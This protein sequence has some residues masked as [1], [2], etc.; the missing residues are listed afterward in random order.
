MCSCKVENYSEISEKLKNILNLDKNPVAVKLFLS[1]QKAEEVLP[2]AE[3]KKRHCERVFDAAEGV[4]CY[5]TLDEQLCQGGAAAL[6]LRDFPDALKTGE[7]YYSLGRFASEGSAKH[8]LE[9]IPKVDTIME[10]V[11]YAPL[12]EAKFEADVIVI[13]ATPEQAMKISQAY[14]YV[15]GKRFKSSFA[16]IQSICSDVVA[17]PF[18][19]KEPNLSLGC[20]GSRKF[21]DVLPTEL[22]VGLT[23]EDIDSF[24]NSLE[25]LS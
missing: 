9:Q 23:A 18:I 24:L 12:G 22:V 1:K 20:G 3:D 14:G 8:E 5:T 25:K 17:S 16:G 15:L 2:K 7:K 11:G 19:S 4:S 10:A 6:G 13:Y 21:T